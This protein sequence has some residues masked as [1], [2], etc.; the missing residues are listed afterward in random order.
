MPFRATIET[1]SGLIRLIGVK[2][3]ERGAKRLAAERAKKYGYAG[4]MRIHNVES[5]QWPISLKRTDEVRW[6]P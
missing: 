1:E 3:T 5:P 2:P 4:M 6:N